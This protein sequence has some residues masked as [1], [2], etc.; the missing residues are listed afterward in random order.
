M[1][2][3][4]AE[5]AAAAAETQVMRRREVEGKLNFVSDL[6]V[7]DAM[8]EADNIV[9]R[10]NNP[11][12]PDGEPI[13][14]EMTPMTP[15]QYAVYYDT[16]LGYSF[17]EVTLAE[18]TTTAQEDIDPLDAAQE[19]VDPLDVEQEQ[20]LQDELAVKKYDEKLL[21]ILESCIQ[22]PPGIT[23]QRLRKWDA[24]YIMRLHNALIGGSRPSKQVAQ[25]PKLDTSG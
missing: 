16:L 3:T 6:D 11:I 20:R 9:A 15:G 4:A 5:V 12:D 24:Y 8:L 25:F 19:D 21:N 2:D 1:K 7:L 23:V 17:T 10:F 18:T 14:F 22:N 13:D